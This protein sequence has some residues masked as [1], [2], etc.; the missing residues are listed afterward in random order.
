MNWLDKKIDEPGSFRLCKAV[1]LPDYAREI[2]RFRCDAHGWGPV[3]VKWTQEG[4][5]FGT[6][7]L[8]GLHNLMDY[9]IVIDCAPYFYVI[10]NKYG[11]GG[12]TDYAVSDSLSKTA[13]E[14]H[15]ETTAPTL[16]LLFRSML[17]WD[18]VFHG[19]FYN[20][21][22]SARLSHNALSI[23]G[24]TPAVRSYF[25]KNYPDLQVSRFLQGDLNA[26]DFPVDGNMVKGIENFLTKILKDFKRRPA[27]EDMWGWAVSSPEIG[28]VD[29]S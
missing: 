5:I 8:Y 20:D 9:D 2:D 28:H 4:D 17:E 25:F 11:D 24:M 7:S 29:F 6:D 13:W 27:R 22:P 14:E 12:I 16:P 3:A 10:Y 21:E 1:F 19:P 18:Y 15:P 23:L 26:K